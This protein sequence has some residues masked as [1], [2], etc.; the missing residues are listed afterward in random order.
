MIS[1]RLD[2]RSREKQG[3]AL[4]KAIVVE[5]GDLI[6]PGREYCLFLTIVCTSTC[7]YN[8]V[9]LSVTCMHVSYMYV[10]YIIN[11]ASRHLRS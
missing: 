2:A 1:G 9:L 4:L 6:S 5:K 3:P 7:I 10:G 11:Q 8:N